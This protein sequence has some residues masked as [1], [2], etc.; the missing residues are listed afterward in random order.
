MK[1]IV[2][3]SASEPPQNL[4]PRRIVSPPHSSACCFRNMEAIG[5]TQR[6]GRWVFQYRRCRTCGFTVRRVLRR[7]PEATGFGK[8]RRIF[9]H[10]RVERL[11]AWE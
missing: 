1:T 3:Y 2:E 11:A 10:M 6:D 5:G 8:L 7:D 4:F 9:A